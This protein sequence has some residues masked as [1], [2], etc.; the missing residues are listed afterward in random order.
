MTRA[1]RHVARS[2]PPG[3]CERRAGWRRSGFSLVELLVVISIILALMAMTGAAISGV[4]ADQKRRAMLSLIQK[5][6]AIITQQFNSYTS[7][8]V[9]AGV[10]APSG[11]SA[12][13]HRSWYIRRYM[14]NGDLPD[15]WVDVKYM[16]DNSDL[17][18]TVASPQFPKDRLS[19]SQ[20][21]YLMTWH[22]M[23]T[24]P[25]DA[26]QGAECLFMI[27]TRGGI[28]SCLDC[29]A[30][31]DAVNGDKDNDGAFEFW[32]SWGNPI[33]FLLWAPALELPANSGEKFFSGKRALEIPGLAGSS[34]P[35]HGLN[36][37]PGLGMRPLIYS[38]GPDGEYG[39]ETQAAASNLAAQT[40][41]STPVGCDCGNWQA[42]PTAVMGNK[43]G[44]TDTRGDN[45]TNFD[46]EAGQ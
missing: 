22:S 46:M 23:A 36:P 15:R 32:D 39:L 5:L 26:F 6:D 3:R 7:R 18:L 33:A 20:R 17:F 10:S 27:I 21:A 44:T 29:N 35:N 14:I 8:I 42:S 1:H 9:P 25:T 31:Q 19:A 24:K 45:I 28:A 40:P 41:G 37:S 4:R 38:A 11:M 13:I 34:G 30:L 43:V 16:Y 2:S 12:S